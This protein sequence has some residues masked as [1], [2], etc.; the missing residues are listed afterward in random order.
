MYNTMRE[1]SLF[2]EKAS[3][4][5]NSMKVRTVRELKEV[6]EELNHEMKQKELHTVFRGVNESHYRL[7]NSF[8]RL[9]NT[10][11]FSELGLEPLQ[12]VQLMLSL[13]NRS[14]VVRKYLKQ[15]GV[16]YNDWLMLSFLQH[17]GAASPLLDFSKN[18]KVALFF[19]CKDVKFYESVKEIDDYISIYYYRNV[20][21]IREKI[22]QSIVNIAKS[23][24]RDVS[25]SKSIKTKVW[26]DTLSFS[27]VLEAENR[28]LVLPTYSNRTSI[29]NKMNQVITTYTT[30]NMNVTSQEGE[31]VCNMDIV[32]PLEDLFQK[33]TDGGNV[34][35]YISC[36]DIHKGLVDYIIREYLGGTIDVATMSYF[37]SEYAIAQQAQQYWMQAL[38]NIN[39]G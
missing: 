10:R 2:E 7:F 39:Q 16:I 8:Q 1:Y 38:P 21:V 4:F 3:H 29:K 19:A 12:A 35:K 31:F 23:T 15:L 13:F 17:Y 5:K 20:D 18:Y 27:K 22:A 11:K 33:K 26:E 14:H 25:P 9:W 6:I 37:P 28:A 34:V 32:T 24:V 30:A 36:V